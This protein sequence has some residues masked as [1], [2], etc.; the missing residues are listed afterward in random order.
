M[1]TIVGILTFISMIKCSFGIL[2]FQFQLIWAILVFMSS[3]NFKLSRV[4]HEKK[5]FI[6]SAPRLGEAME[7][8]V[9]KWLVHHVRSQNVF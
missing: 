4:G 6:T 1:P 9:A 7:H 2:N 8:S 3:L 5:S